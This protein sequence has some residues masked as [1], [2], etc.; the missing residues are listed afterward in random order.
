MFKL[1]ATVLL[2][3]APVAFAQRIDSEGPPAYQYSSTGILQRD[4]E[5]ASIQDE[6]DLALGFGVLAAGSGI[7]SA[8]LGLLALGLDAICDPCRPDQNSYIVAF[9]GVSAVFGGIMVLAIPFAIGLTVDAGSRRARRMQLGL[10][11]GGI[12]FRI[13]L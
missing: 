2:L 3:V 12:S 4:P 8:G 6:S 13:E 1:A 11:P 9:L 7:T 10:G 5:L